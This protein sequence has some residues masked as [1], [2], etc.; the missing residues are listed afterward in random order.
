MNEPEKAATLI[1]LNCGAFAQDL[2]GMTYEEYLKEYS[3]TCGVVDG[4]SNDV[5]NWSVSM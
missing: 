5:D 1:V 3:R 4:T 2:A